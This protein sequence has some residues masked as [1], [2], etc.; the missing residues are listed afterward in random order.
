VKIVNASLHHINHDVDTIEPKDI[1]KGGARLDEYVNKLLNEI[2][3]SSRKREFRFR[4][5]K[6]EVA[7][8]I[9][10]MFNGNFTTESEN[11]AKRL[12]SKEKVAQA[13]IDHLNVEI[14]KGSLFQ[15]TV[16]M[17]NGDQQI[18]ISKADHSTILDEID[19]QLHHG[20]P[21]DKK[22]F[23]AM[24]AKFSGGTIDL[25]N[26]YDTN[27]QMTKYWWYDFLELE[28]IYDDTHNTKTSLDA[29]ELK[30][31]DPIKK[32]YRLD[33]NVLRNS[34]IGYFRSKPE[35]EVEDFIE[36]VLKDYEPYDNNL[37]IDTL[38]SKVR[39]FPEKYKFD[40]RFD[41]SKDDI[42]KRMTQVF[43]LRANLDLVLR[44][45]VNRISDI[46]E[47]YRDDEGNPFIKI[48]IDEIAYNQF[49]E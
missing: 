5:D 17:D 9:P 2:A 40:Q 32:N 18:V 30:L 20:L 43:H 16:Q 36:T 7:A 31:F 6:T 15:A 41:I 27:P 25:V 4:S 10:K 45:P 42:R 8:A 1:A 35:F 39:A 47:R 11:I 49:P 26:I 28:R 19:F 14:Q 12:L 21:W 13:A 22:T 37:K 38:I 44:E 23:K 24:S 29:L 34:A 3:T 46:V 48:G 33:H